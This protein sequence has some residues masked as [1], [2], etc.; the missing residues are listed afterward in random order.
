[1]RARCVHATTE[2]VQSGAQGKDGAGTRATSPAGGKHNNEAVPTFTGAQ[3]LRQTHRLV[4]FC[5]QHV[6]PER[7]D[8]NIGSAQI[9][10]A[11]KE[12][13][14]VIVLDS[15]ER[16][17]GVG[18]VWSRIRARWKKRGRLSG[19][20]WKGTGRNLRTQRTMQSL[21]DLLVRLAHPKHDGSLCNQAG[22]RRLSL[23]VHMFE[24]NAMLELRVRGT[25]AIEAQQRWQASV[26]CVSLSKT[27]AL[28]ANVVDVA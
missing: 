25:C 18:R 14:Q 13:Q 23:H 5:R 28:L 20:A 9:C 12:H 19:A 2:W 3:T 27:A 26:C 17:H 15:R 21:E 11:A 6:L 4:F 24:P 1:M 8:I 7:D 10:A 16:P 22:D